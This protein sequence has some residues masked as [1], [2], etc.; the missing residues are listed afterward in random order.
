MKPKIIFT[1]SAKPFIFKALSITVGDDGFIY[2]DGELALDM[3]DNKPVLEKDFAG[4]H[5]NGIIKG[6]LH[7]IMNLVKHEDE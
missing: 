4:I 1:D 6:D 3:F 5:K 7:S 2:K